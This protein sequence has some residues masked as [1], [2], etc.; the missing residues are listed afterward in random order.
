[1]KKTATGFSPSLPK[2]ALPEAPLS[3]YFTMKPSAAAPA[4][5]KFPSDNFCQE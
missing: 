5:G 4:A 1:M 3:G 2:P